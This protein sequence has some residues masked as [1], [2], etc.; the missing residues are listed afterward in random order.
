MP[1]FE[2]PDGP[3]TVELKRSGDPKNPAPVQ[4]SAVFNVTNKSAQGCDGRLSVQVAGSSKAEWF[5]VDGDRER[6]FDAGQT[7]TANIKISIPP[8]VAPGDYP[9]RL[10]AV[11]VNDPDNDHSEGPVTTAKVIGADTP[12]APTKWWLW[13]LI[14]LVVLAVIGGIVWYVMQPAKPTPTPPAPTSQR[15]E[16]AA[17]TVPVPRFVDQTV[18]QAKADAHGFHIVEIAGTPS[19]K[20]PRTILS[21]VPDVGSPQ[22]GGAVVQV[23]LDPGVPVPDLKEQSVSQAV[24]TLDHAGLHMQHKTTGCESGTPDVIMDQH[25]RPKEGPVAKDSGV[26]VVVRTVGGK[27]YGKYSIGCGV[28]IPLNVLVA[29]LPAQEKARAIESAKISTF[30]KPQ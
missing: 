26:D 18:E 1:T 15:N 6:T 22:Q 13:I 28:I 25:P 7:Q 30:T 2:I 27:L 11:A 21:Q 24:D 23:T 4:G 19:G 9:F 5:T 20:Q 10:R 14:G 12:A 16:V 29:P 17:T 3:T 8:D